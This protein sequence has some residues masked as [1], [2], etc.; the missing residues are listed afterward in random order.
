MIYTL[1]A[2]NPEKLLSL[3]DRN[4][5]PY[6]R[7]LIHERA[8]QWRKSAWAYAMAR[9]RPVFVGL[10]VVE[11]QFG[12]KDPGRRRDPNNFARTT[13]PIVDG[14]VDAGVFVDDD[15]AHVDQRQ[16]TFTDTL[17]HH[18]YRVTVTGDAL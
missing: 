11:I 17:P 6:Q 9:P 1:V 2:P 12:V 5:T 10:A 15:S 3:N 18:H 14:L 7:R 8:A 16:P 13:K 4:G